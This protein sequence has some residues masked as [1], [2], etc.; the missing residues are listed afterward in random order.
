MKNH[1]SRIKIP[2]KI[3]LWG[4][5][6]ALQKGPAMLATFKPAFELQVGKEVDKEDLAIHPQSPAGQWIAKHGSDFEKQKL[7]FSDPLKGQGG[8]GASTAQFALSYAFAEPEYDIWQMHKDYV[9]MASTGQGSAPSGYD[10]LAQVQGGIQFIEAKNQTLKSMNFPFKDLQIYFLHTGRKLATHEH[11]QTVKTQ[12]YSQLEKISRQL[13]E[14]WERQD[15][16]V[17]VSLINDYADELER[18][19]LVS[20]F[21]KSALCELQKESW[22]LAAK[23]CGAMGADL[24]MIVT[25]KNLYSYENILEF[26]RKHQCQLLT[27]LDQVSEKGLEFIHE[28]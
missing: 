4:E 8:L 13:V 21:T 14:A 2:G 7:H 19:N 28:I 24:I 11:L 5:Y 3:F 22:S 16:R 6:V 20:E 27:Q 15:Q 17:W 9:Q 18:I 1:L 25:E 26:A 10:L 12:E 23:G